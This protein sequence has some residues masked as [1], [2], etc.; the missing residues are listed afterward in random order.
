MTGVKR[1]GILNEEKRYRSTQKHTFFILQV[2]SSSNLGSDDKIFVKFLS[3]LDKLGG[4]VEIQLK[5]PIKYKIGSCMSKVLTLD[6]MT[7]YNDKPNICSISRG[8]TALS[9]SCNDKEVVQYLYSSSN[10]RKYPRPRGNKTM[11]P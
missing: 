4:T 2:K 8:K 1:G 7:S 3:D 5:N 9:I 10:T 11:I 6:E